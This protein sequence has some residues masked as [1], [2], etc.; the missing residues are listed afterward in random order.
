MNRIYLQLLLVVSIVSAVLTSCGEAMEWNDTTTTNGAPDVQRQMVMHEV[1]V[2]IDDA[3]TRVAYTPDNNIQDNNTPTNNTPGLR[4]SWEADETLGVYI[5]KT[6]NSIVYAGTVSYTGG[7]AGYGVRE[8][9]GTVSKLNNGEQY[10]YMHPAVSD[11]TVGSAAAGNIG[12]ASQSGKLGSTAHLKQFVPLVWRDN[13]EPILTAEKQAYVVRVL[14]QFN[15]DPGKITSV[16]LRTMKMGDDGTTPDKI[17]PKYFNTANLANGVNNTLATEKTAGTTLSGDAAYTDEITLGISSSVP[18]KVGTMW[19]AD[20][21]IAVPSINNLDVFRTKYDVKV[22]AEK[23]TYYSD[24]RSFPEQGSTTA[25]TG[26]PMLTDG[27]CYNLRA[28]MSKSYAMT[29][30]S[31]QFRV[32]SLLGMWNT[33]GK[34]YDPFGLVVYDGE[35]VVSGASIPAQLKNNKDAILTRYKNNGTGTPTWLGAGNGT[36]YDVTANAYSNNLRQDNVII[37]NIEIT[38]PTEVFVTFI[39]EFGWNENLL[40]YYHYDTDNVPE[41]SIGVRKT[42]IFPNVSKPNHQPFNL[43]GSGSGSTGAGVNIGT[44]DQA[45]L[46]EFE[47]VKLLYTDA[48]GYTSTTFPAG[49]IIG[50]M[51][52]IDTEAQ[53]SSPKSGYNLLKWSQWRLF[54]NTTWNKENTRANGAAADWPLPYGYTRW[55]YFCSGDVCNGSGNPIQ[56]LAI[57]GIKDDAKN[58]T[59]TAYGAMIFMVSTSDPSAMETWNKAYFNI[60]T[61]NI[62]ISK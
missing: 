57:Y 10:I 3:A 7:T 50:F 29:I 61:G 43:N 16:A 14:L 5:K 6:D 33:Y 25:A 17:F 45:P 28:N 21:Y 12:Y 1:T 30:I 32:N 11:E 59:N 52:M 44:P 47:T 13:G 60:G 53:E 42:L 23:G 15:E 18:K 4:L 8:F 51:M 55:N 58:D 56:G 39:S 19:K 26:L 34:P 48:N 35:S 46:R 2:S 36:L 37:N 27:K 41:S 62:V 49:T 54:T 31:E 22:I 20:A 38:K 9:R 24:Y 40:G